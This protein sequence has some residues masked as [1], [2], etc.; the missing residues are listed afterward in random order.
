MRKKKVLLLSLA[1]VAGLALAAGIA[2]VVMIGP[3]NVIGMLRYDIRRPGD[4]VVG[5]VAPDVTLVTLD[6]ERVRL[7]ERF[8]ARPTVLVFG[9]F[10]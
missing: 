4:Y 1:V 10:T 7:A 3:S 8:G 9:S 2:M 6:G 5:D